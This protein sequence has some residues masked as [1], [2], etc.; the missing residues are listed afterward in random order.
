MAMLCP[1]INVKYRIEISKYRNI[2]YFSSSDAT[3]I[4]N[5]NISIR[6]RIPI[7]VDVA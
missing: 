4:A 2:Q 7:R 6:V 1:S 3:K 5:I